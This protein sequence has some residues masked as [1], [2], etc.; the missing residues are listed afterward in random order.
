M[1]TKNQPHNNI[2]KNQN[3]A[4]FNTTKK[5]IIQQNAGQTSNTTIIPLDHKYDSY[6]FTGTIFGVIFLIIIL[7]LIFLYYYK[8]RKKIKVKKIETS[9]QIV[10]QNPRQVSPRVFQTL[11]NSSNVSDT[12]THTSINSLSEIK[13]ANNPDNQELSDELNNIMN[14]SGSSSSGRRR[15][16][17]RKSG[18]SEG[19]IKAKRDDFDSNLKKEIQDQIKQY[20]IDE[21]NK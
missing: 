5:N 14:N 6:I 19:L 20:V 10:I 21:H 1:A 15:R 13:A 8:R 11:Q 12:N 16:E 7:F 18:N 2:N 4:N 9:N 17:K 3:F